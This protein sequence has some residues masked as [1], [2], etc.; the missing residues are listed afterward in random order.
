MDILR[1]ADDIDNYIITPICLG[2]AIAAGT[3]L[4]VFVLKQAGKQ[5]LKKGVKQ[6]AKKKIKENAEKKIIK[7]T[8]KSN[9]D[10][11]PTEKTDIGE[12]LNGN[13]KLDNYNYNLNTLQDS[14]SQLGKYTHMRN[15]WG[16]ISKNYPY[17]HLGY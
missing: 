2:A 9:V 5:A 17:G 10:A 3:G 8:G 14:Q 16:D 13:K 1:V 4:G 11:K 7:R 6:L 12:L 15:T